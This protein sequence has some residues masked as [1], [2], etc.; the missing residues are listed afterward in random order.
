M[1][2]HKKSYSEDEKLPA[3]NIERLRAFAEAAGFRSIAALSEAVATGGDPNLLGRA[4]ARDRNLKLIEAVR[5]AK[6]LNV[7][8]R[9][10]LI[11]FGYEG[12]SPV[13]VPVTGR[14]A[15]NGQV[16]FYQR[17]TRTVDGPDESNPYWRCLIM[18]SANSALAAYDQFQFFYE[19]SE[20]LVP[21]A[22]GRL[23][24]IIFDD[25]NIK[26]MLATI[27]R[28]LGA[29]A[30]IELFGGTER[31]EVRNIKTAAPILWIRC[32]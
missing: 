26:P 13:A 10:L 7:P 8:F 29:H 2:K 22:Y 18:Q 16:S 12:V 32:A 21:R 19:A 23:A 14:V 20:D 4:L 1:P 6:A 31:L 3:P 30:T 11:A 17:E 5:M 24:L 28:S 15:P 25:A 27:V 9:Q